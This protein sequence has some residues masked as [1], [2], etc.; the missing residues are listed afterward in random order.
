[1]GVFQLRYN[2][3]QFSPNL[4]P[5]LVALFMVP[6]LIALGMWQLNR[7][8][9]KGL[10][11]SNVEEAQ[12]KS[13]L[14]INLFVESQNDFSSQIYRSA[15]LVGQYDKRVNFLLDNRTY[16]GR[17]GFH[18]LTPFFL[19]TSESEPK[20]VLINRGW[21]TYK[22]ERSNIPK[23]TV[24]NKKTEI[25]GIIKKVGKSIVLKN[26]EASSASLQKTYPKIIQAI[27]LDKLSKE[28][29]YELLPIVIQLDKSAKSGFI[30]EWQPYYGTVDK[31]I[32]YSVQWFSMAAVLFLLFIKVNTKKLVS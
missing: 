4:I 8:D 30:R 28:L 13:P 3:Y 20:A 9:E 1:M 5:T 31:H 32:A 2:N 26:D 10:I 7:A 24:S 25:L 15:S 29:N 22:G 14:Q 16:K 27:S 18:V 21:I 19:G 12:Q 11:D 17:A 23:I 6:G